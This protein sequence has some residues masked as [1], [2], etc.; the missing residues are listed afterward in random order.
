MR[1]FSVNC[2]PDA[3]ESLRAI[4]KMWARIGTTQPNI[5]FRALDVSAET[6]PDLFRYKVQLDPALSEVEV[7]R[8]KQLAELWSMLSPAKNSE[9][10][11]DCEL[12]ASIVEFDRCRRQIYGEPVG[13][14]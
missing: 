9:L 13:A 11:M 3:I 7:A 5:L 14:S 2:H 4:A 1:S 8:L 10:L 12:A 6:R